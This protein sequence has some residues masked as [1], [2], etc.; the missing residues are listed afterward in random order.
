MTTVENK[1]PGV[2]NLVKQTDFNTKVTEIKRNSSGLATKTELTAVEIK[3]PS[4]SNLVKKSKITEIEKKLMS[5]N[6]TNTLLLKNLMSLH[7]KM[8][9]EK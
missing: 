5:I 6:M 3:I 1:I 9:L 8:L 4:V 2:N 7:Q